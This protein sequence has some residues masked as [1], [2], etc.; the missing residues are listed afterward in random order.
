M[1]EFPT[2]NGV[3]TVIPPPPGYEVNF[4][5]PQQKLAYEHYGLFAVGGFLSLLAILQRYYTKIYLTK[6]L[7]MDDGKC[8]VTFLENHYILI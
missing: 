6:G 4:A 8:P 3:T 2:V 1:P 7:Q 5:N